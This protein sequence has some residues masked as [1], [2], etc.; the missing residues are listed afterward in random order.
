MLIVM[1]LLTQIKVN[2]NFIY[3]EEKIDL[4]NILEE[5]AFETDKEFLEEGILG[6][7]AKTIK[8]WIVRFLKKVLEKIKRFIMSSTSAIYGNPKKFPTEETAPPMP[9]SPYALSKLMAELYCKQYSQLYKVET[10][11][12][13]YANV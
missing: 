6:R 3:K 10:I 1:Q 13:R 8:N 7:A 12:L 2:I 4:D 11:S 5:S 9:M